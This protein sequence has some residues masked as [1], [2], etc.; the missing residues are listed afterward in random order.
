MLNMH[1]VKEN[2]LALYLETVKDS[3]CPTFDDS[4]EATGLF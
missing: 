1:T 4:S 2:L 3:D